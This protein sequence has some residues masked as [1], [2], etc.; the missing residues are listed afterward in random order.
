MSWYYILPQSV[1]RSGEKHKHPSLELRASFKYYHRSLYQPMCVTEG[2]SSAP[3]T[4]LIFLCCYSGH[5]NPPT[6]RAPCIQCSLFYRKWIFV[7]ALVVTHRKGQINL[8]L[9]APDKNCLHS[10]DTVL[11]QQSPAFMTC[12]NYCA[13]RAVSLN[14]FQNACD[15]MSR[16]SRSANL[17][18]SC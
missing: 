18:Q 15:S 2:Y 9:G 3:K 4:R 11:A 16:V 10:S 8:C 1:T 13:C 17:N 12:Q 14:I 5:P 7:S 6:P